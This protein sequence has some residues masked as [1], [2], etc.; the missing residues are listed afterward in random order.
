MAAF[1]CHSEAHWFGVRNI[2]G[3]WYNLNSTLGK[4]PQLVP[5]AEMKKFL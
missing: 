1:L 3:K 4:M 5:S 2:K